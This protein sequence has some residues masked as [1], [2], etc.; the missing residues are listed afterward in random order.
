GN[1]VGLLLGS[2]RRVA[3]FPPGT[4]WW[5]GEVLGAAFV[6]PALRP[7]SWALLGVFV[8]GNVANL[9][10]L[11]R[12]IGRIRFSIRGLMATVAAVAI[13]CA[14]LRYVPILGLVL[15]VMAS[16]LPATMLRQ[17]RRRSAVELEISGP[18]PS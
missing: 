18:T 1:L 10:G 17:S 4:R 16:L 15:V 14:S 2:S 13:V 6:R 5:W 3:S 12:E 7:I 9:W 11:R 8:A